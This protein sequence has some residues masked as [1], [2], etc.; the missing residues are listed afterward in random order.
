MLIGFNSL[1][2]QFT[3]IIGKSLL[4]FQLKPFDAEISLLF[5][6]SLTVMH[7]V[8]NT[9]VNIYYTYLMIGVNSI[10]ITVSHY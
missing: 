3:F 6:R 1:A 9:R 5:V 7:S 10:I 2:N 4:S 8:Y